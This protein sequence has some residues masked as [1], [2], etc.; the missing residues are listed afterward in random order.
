MYIFDKNTIQSR[1]ERAKKAFDGVIS[2]D[3]LILFFSG[4]PITKPG[5]FDQSYPFLPHPE[6]YWISGLRRAWG[7][8][9]YS[10]NDGWVDFVQQITAD[11]KLWEGSSG[12]LEGLNVSELE[13]WVSKKS[14][15]EVFVFG[16]YEQNQMNGKPIKL[17]A[18]PDQNKFLDLKETLNN[19]RRVKDQAEVNIIKRCAAAALQGYLVLEKF[20][21]SGVSE[22]EIQ[23]AYETA[24]LKAGSDKFPYDT[25]VGSGTNAAIL[26]AIPTQKV[27]E[28]N[29]LVLIDA[30]AD[31]EDYCVDI[32]RVYSATG[33]FTDKQQAI[34]DL[35]LKAQTKGI[36]MC[37][38]KTQ[39]HDV[40]NACG[41]IM[42][43]GLKDLNI[44]NCSAD[45]AL[46]TGAIS[47]F[48]P[49]GVGHLVGLR[50]RDV[51]GVANKPVQKYNGVNL[52]VDFPLQENYL[53]TV[54]PGLYFV[55]ALIENEELRAKHKSTVNWN[56]VEKW[57]SVGGVR[58][59]DDILVGQTPT[60]LTAAVKK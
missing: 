39:W 9:A 5:G 4:E 50:V 32:T 1:R 59:E 33:K 11:E 42:A 51:G 25:I 57:R 35:V 23:I 31:I 21:K 18:R 34:Y 17:P 28:G 55:K 44:L 10:K 36:S 24:V 26:H 58:I 37:T 49:H 47:V 56:E 6:Y 20:I 30:G 52:R 16:Q 60:N 45:E 12:D 48:F 29:E 41:R 7:V 3:A 13:S 40:H 54:E 53:V 46:E 15:K 14:F 8:V 19:V 2:N 27:V 38:P 22:R 43:Q